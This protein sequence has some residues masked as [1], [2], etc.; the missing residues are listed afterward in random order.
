MHG[1]K[2]KGKKWCILT[3]QVTDDDEQYE[4]F[5]QVDIMDYVML[6]QSY[7]H[8]DVCLPFVL[9]TFPIYTENQV[10][11]KKKKNNICSIK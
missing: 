8:A 7:C 1:N 10:P 6:M 4:L 11:K 9:Y 3:L 2:N 5:G